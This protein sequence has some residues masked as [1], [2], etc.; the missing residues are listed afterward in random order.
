MQA[1]CLSLETT[2]S[3]NTPQI[4]SHLPRSESGCPSSAARFWPRAEG[5][6]ARWTA[7]AWSLSACSALQP[8]ARFARATDQM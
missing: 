2:A 6:C 4:G 5:A 8:G 1:N 3:R 7:S